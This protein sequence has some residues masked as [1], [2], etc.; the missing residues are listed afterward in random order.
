V[1]S[2]I[3]PEQ[4]AE[5]VISVRRYSSQQQARALIARVVMTTE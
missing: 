5:F 3:V 4:L 2:I 1:T